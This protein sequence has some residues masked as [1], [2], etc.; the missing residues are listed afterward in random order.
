MEKPK[1]VAI[2]LFEGVNALDVS[3]PAEA[4]ATTRDCSGEAAYAIETWGLDA[5]EFQTESGLKLVADGLL[6]EGEPCDILIIP[7]GRGARLQ[8]TVEAL[9]TWLKDN[10][11]SCERVVSVCTGAYPLAHSGLVDELT[12]TTHW[13]HEADLQAR[14]P[15]VSVQAD[16]LFLNDEKYYSSGGVASGIDLALEIIREDFGHEAAMDVAREMVVFLRRDGGQSQFSKLLQLQSQTDDPIQK[17]C[18]WAAA[19]LDADLSNEILA[20]KARLSVRQFTRKF[21]EAIGEPPATHINRMRIEAA[22]S[23][24]SQRAN[25]AQTAHAVGFG[26][27]DGF[28][29]SF[30]KLTGIT[31]T[32]FQARFGQ[33][34]DHS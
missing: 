8:E 33:A 19:N 1:R 31:P 32:Q 26:S 18:R 24:L 28:R 5:V 20:A 23:A 25:V 2:V 11:Q 7:G 29:K 10:A 34:E 9:A 13:A 12:L 30:E 16:Q 15:D 3:G 17:A 22:K 27:T 4:F 6:P 21:I 14:Y